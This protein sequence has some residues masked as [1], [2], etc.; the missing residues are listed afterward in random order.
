MRRRLLPGFV[1]IQPKS[2]SG[3][4]FS[5]STGHWPVPHGD[6]PG[7]TGTAPGVNKDAPLGRSRRALPVGESPTGTG[8][9]PVLP[10]FQTRS[11]KPPSLNFVSTRTVKDILCPVAV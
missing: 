2:V 8:E 7:G 9:S 4:L 3:N 5:G 6:S 11:K 1:T 10:I